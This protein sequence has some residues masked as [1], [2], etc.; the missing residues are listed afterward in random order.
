MFGENRNLKTSQQRNKFFDTQSCL[1]KNSAQSTPVE[2]LVIG[3]NNLGKWLFTSED[4]MTSILPFKLK[5]L[6]S[7]C[8]NALAP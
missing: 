5:S 7:E 3:N 1:T 8:G 2:L 6:F 4:D